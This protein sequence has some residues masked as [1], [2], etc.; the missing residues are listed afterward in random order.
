MSYS[1]SP[2]PNQLEP[3][4]WTLPKPH[5]PGIAVWVYLIALLMLTLTG[6]SGCASQVPQDPKPFIN[7]LA[8]LERGSSVPSELR[9]PCARPT[10]PEKP[11]SLDNVLPF[12]LN[13]E[14]ATT[15]CE[16]ERD[17][18]V[19]LYDQLRKAAGDLR[20]ELTKGLKAAQITVRP[21]PF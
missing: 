9:K 8:S 16:Q 5:W 19:D 20:V 10:Y 11:L 17:Q 14:A 2:H 3:Q 4:P 18:A 6:L 1:S 13:Q 15:L 7:A 12:S 21:W